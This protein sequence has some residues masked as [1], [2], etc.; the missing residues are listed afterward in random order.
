MVQ[1]A[2]AGEKPDALK[3]ILPTSTNFDLYINTDYPGGIYNIGLW[4]WFRPFIAKL[5]QNHYSPDTN[6]FPGAPA[7]DED[8]DGE[9]IDEIPLDLDGSGSFL[10]DGYQLPGNPPQY[11]DGNE[12]QHIYYLASLEHLGNKEFLESPD[13]LVFRDA[14]GAGGY[15][16]ADRQ[17]GDR[18]VHMAE[19]GIPVYNTGGW[20]DIFITATTQWHSTLRATN[21]SRL[22]IGP[23]NHSGPGFSKTKPNGPYWE[24]FGEDKEELWE[25]YNLEKL[26]FLDHY[27][28]GTE[29]NIDKEPPVYIYVMNGEGWRFED[30]WPIER[31]KTETL[32]FEEGNTLSVTRKNEGHDN[33]TADYTHD[34]R[35]LSSEKNRYTL[36]SQ[37]NVAIRNENDLKC[38]T[39]TMD[40][41]E[42]DMEVTGHPIVHLWVSSTADYGD[43]FVYLEDVDE[44]GDAYFVTDGLHRAGFATL[45]PNEDILL[46]PDSGID[47]LP[48]TPWHGYDQAHFTDRI[49]AG[50]NIAEVVFDLQPTS[51][52]FKKGH[53][54]RV[55]IACADWPTFMLH[56]K[57]SPGNDPEDPDIIVPTITVYRDSEHRSRIDLPVIPS[58]PV[59]KVSE[60]LRYS[61]YTSPDYTGYDRSAQ[62]VTV[63]DGT[64]LAMVWYTPTG[65]PSE[66]PFPVIFTYYPYHY[67][68]INVETGELIP[69][70]KNAME[71]YASYGYVI[72]VADMRGSGASFGVRNN[73]S[74]QLGLD[75]KDLVDWIAQQPWCDGNIGMMGASYMGGSQFATA[76]QK[77]AALKCIMPGFTGFDSYSRI[78]QYAGGIRQRG[79]VFSMWGP[80]Y[81]DRNVYWP[82]FPLL[83]GRP[84]TPMIDED[85][86]GELADEIPI[87]QDG[88]GSFV[89][90]YQLPDNP[91]QY[92]DGEEREHIYFKLTL[93]HMQNPY[94]IDAAMRFRDEQV[95][96]E[97]EDTFARYGAGDY[98]IG[99]AESGIPIYNTAGWFDQY[100]TA[101]TLWYKTLEKTNPSRMIIAPVVHAWLGVIDQPRGPYVENVAELEKGFNLE[102]LRYFDYH[103]KGIDNGIDSEP[104]VWIFVMNG[105]GW[106]AENEWPLS[107]Q[108]MT[109]YY[110]NHENSLATEKSSE[111][112]DDYQA[113]F[114]HDARDDSTDGSRWGGFGKLTS[115]RTRT[116]EDEQ[117]LTYTMKEPLEEDTEITGH[118]VVHLWVSST[119]DYGDLFVYLE[120][121]DE[122]GN[123]YY[124]TEG[125]HR[126]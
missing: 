15:T 10:D 41:L 20:F 63:T 32:Y 91:P 84:A 21:P 18:P 73:I 64:K 100:V 67:E 95:V 30:E 44:N 29:N 26:R 11:S 34:S 87:D 60:P 123:A 54:I 106:R 65:G 42:E 43:F 76:A 5:D 40:P 33:Y 110:F 117:C 120:D 49:F 122:E 126:A 6:T 125:Q 47:V 114:T 118:P 83:L 78:G 39:Y 103:L 57:L 31:Q 96:A 115:P 77:P 104:P 121:V 22:L 17:P 81:F 55:S 85:G 50:G 101:T 46:T 88:D 24:Y 35:E 8:M 74:K 79:G 1:F 102:R 61:G 53:R 90:D 70:I 36:G 94:V 9:I 75:G 37:H 58:E 52:V 111:G 72:A 13:D 116:G 113:D 7:V 66:G 27:L 107:R 71:L 56:P 12:R 68:A 80:T 105:E 2:T 14:T 93:E 99:L 98:P 28:K 92:I 45:V 108:K 86:D 119:E 109:D 124:V 82:D 25:G 62:Y 69:I 3:C 89:E 19:S 38:L 16:F 112:S 51:W 48:D 59:E 97:S 4:G 23:N